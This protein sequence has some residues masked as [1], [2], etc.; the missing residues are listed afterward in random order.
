MRSGLGKEGRPALGN[1]HLS[2]DGGSGCGV[3]P[4]E[5]PLEAPS[6]GRRSSAQEPSVAR[7]A[8]GFCGVAGEVGSL[9]VKYEQPGLE[10]VTIR[11][12]PAT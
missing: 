4:Q 7:R 2:P 1:R 11:G 9:V 12:V 3:S 10:V 5:G 6:T 8:A